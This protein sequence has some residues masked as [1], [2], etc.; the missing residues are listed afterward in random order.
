MKKRARIID[1][2]NKNIYSG[3]QA[4][5]PDSAIDDLSKPVSKETSKRTPTKIT[6][7]GFT[8]RKHSTKFTEEGMETE[9]QEPMLLDGMNR[10]VKEDEIQGKCDECG[11]YA[12]QI[13]HCY[14]QGCKKTLCPRHV[15][16][17]EKEG[18][19]IPYCLTDYNHVVDN[20]DTWQAD[21]ERRRNK[22]EKQ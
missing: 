14:V 19:Q 1:K 9:T 2:T 22:N 13:F 6:D 10:R 5:S 4:Q 3:S 16:F 21:A 7:N 17:F 12:A 11:E 18:K 15:Y 20:F 8:V